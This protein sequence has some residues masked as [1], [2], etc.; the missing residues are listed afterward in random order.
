[1]V[2]HVKFHVAAPV[3]LVKALSLT[4]ATA[5]KASLV[6]LPASR[7]PSAL[8]P[9]ATGAPLPVA[10]GAP[11]HVAAGALLPVSATSA[12]G[13]GGGGEGGGG[14]GEARVADATLLAAAPH[15][16]VARA[17]AAAALSGA[18]SST[19]VP[20]PSPPSSRA[21]VCRA[22][23]RRVAGREDLSGGQRSRR[24]S[25][26]FPSPPYRFLPP[27]RL[28]CP[29]LLLHATSTA[30]VPLAAPPSTKAPQENA[31]ASP[32]DQ[33]MESAKGKAEWNGEG[34]EAKGKAE[35]NGEGEEAK[36]KAEGNGEGEEVKRKAEGNG[37]GEEAKGKAEGNGEGKEAKGKA[38]QSAD[39]EEGKSS[40]V[41]GLR[42]VT[43][44]V[45][46][47]DVT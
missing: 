8:P 36:G 1:M 41:V 42:L 10:A 19:F 29:R 33:G 30:A 9:V 15:R 40:A 32:F 12:V 6:R 23:R 16:Y 35:G 22:G 5:T 26:P 3:A 45:V 25:R 14:G 7:R 17:P 13:G 4:A 44:P 47:A 38:E 24:S 46:A 11:L 20:S 2:L 39:G 31:A 18:R 34:E 28:S 43:T 21:H 27:R 37:E